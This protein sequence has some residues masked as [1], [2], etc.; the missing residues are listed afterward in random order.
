[1]NLL[2]KAYTKAILFTAPFVL[3]TGCASSTSSTDAGTLQ[4]QDGLDVTS[5]DFKAAFTGATGLAW[6]ALVVVETIALISC[7][8]A[9]AVSAG[10]LG[11]AGDQ[12][13][14]AEAKES[15]LHSC[16]ATAVIGAFPLIAY[17]ILQIL[18]IVQSR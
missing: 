1:M 10:R 9:I 13:Q 16:I 3:L 17:L 8:A 7:I 15:L 18:S 2:K 6:Q 12:N 14:R 4:S 11:K 5:E